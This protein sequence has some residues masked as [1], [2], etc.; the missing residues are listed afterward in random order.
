MRVPCFLESV[1]EA[2]A[3][4]LSKA[5]AMLISCPINRG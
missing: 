5:A 3:E 4:G 1:E 2:R